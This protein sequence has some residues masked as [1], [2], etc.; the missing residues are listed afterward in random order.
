[1]GGSSLSED[2]WGRLLS[3]LAIWIASCLRRVP[4]RSTGLLGIAGESGFL[5]CQ[6]DLAINL[7]GDIVE[8]GF[9]NYSAPTSRTPCTAK[10]GGWSLLKLDSSRNAKLI[11]ETVGVKSGNSNL[12]DYLRNAVVI[13][14][15][16]MFDV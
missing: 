3:G 11:E 2:P 13:G 6:V 16:G 7:I 1:M 8:R 9:L 4:G 14:G 10:V 15:S 5:S 12:A